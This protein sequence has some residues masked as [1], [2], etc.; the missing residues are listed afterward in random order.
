V[1]EL[2]TDHDGVVGQR[3]LQGKSCAAIVEALVMILA[4]AIHPELVAEPASSSKGELVAV[5][6]APPPLRRRPRGGID[7]G[8]PI[9]LG[10][11]VEG[12]VHL[13]AFAFARP[14]LGAGLEL[15][16]ARA[17]LRVVTTYDPEQ[18]SFLSGQS[19]G[20]ALSIVGVG[21]SACYTLAEADYFILAPCAGAWWSRAFGRGV[22]IDGAQHN[23]L[24][25]LSGELGGL[26]LWRL[27]HLQARFD[28][29]VLLPG[30]RPTAFLSY[31]DGARDVARLSVAEGRAGFGVGIVF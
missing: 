29:S 15:E 6:P 13:G 8:G 4:L 11:F 3:R 25:W 19:S 5:T 22:G 17:R 31:P 14:T 12:G 1:L 10:A 30:R 18:T 7:G 20:V 28:A 9:R 24:E 27:E 23:S 26:L 16:Q 2:R 21:V